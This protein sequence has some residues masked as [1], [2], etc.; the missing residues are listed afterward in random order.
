MA[1]SGRFRQLDWT[2]PIERM[3]EGH[4]SHCCRASVVRHSRGASTA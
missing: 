3:V 4:D 2:E 1:M